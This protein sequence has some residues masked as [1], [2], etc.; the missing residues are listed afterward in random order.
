MLHPEKQKYIKNCLV[1][2]LRGMKMNL[3]KD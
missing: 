2:T 3:M 1:K